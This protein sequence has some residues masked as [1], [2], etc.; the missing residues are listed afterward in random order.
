MRGERNQAMQVKRDRRVCS[1]D[2]RTARALRDSRRKYN[3]VSHVRQASGPEISHLKFETLRALRRVKRECRLGV[4]ACRRRWIRA[5][6]RFK[7]TDCIVRWK[8][9]KRRPTGVQNADAVVKG[10]S[11]IGRIKSSNTAT[12][13]SPFTPTTNPFD[14]LNCTRRIRS[15]TRLTR[16]PLLLKPTT[17]IIPSLGHSVT[18]FHTPRS[19][20]GSSA[21]P[22]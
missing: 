4:A 16:F 19:P 6:E 11:K 8:S 10:R 18:Q 20:V 12:R 14:S 13:L 17:P 15:R 9:S 21:L 3:S 7:L 2:L 1:T 22:P 5:P